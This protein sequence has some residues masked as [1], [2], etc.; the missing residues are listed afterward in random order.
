MKKSKWKRV[1]AFGLAAVMLLGSAGCTKKDKKDQ[2]GDGSNT[3]ADPSLAK[4]YVYHYEDLNLDIGADDYNISAFRK[5]GDKLELLVN[6][7]VY[8][9]SDDNQVFYLITMNADGSNCQ[10]V[11]MESLGGGNNSEE[12]IA[13][14]ED[15]ETE[16]ENDDEVR[17]VDG[18]QTEDY[19]YE[20]SYYQGSCLGD[21]GVY[22][23]RTHQTESYQNGEYNST[24]DVT[25]C[26]WNKDGSFRNGVPFDLTQYQNE[27]TYSYISKMIAIGD[28]SIALLLGGDQS[29]LISIDENGNVKNLQQNKDMQEVFSNDPTFVEGKDGKLLVSY[30]TDD[31]SKMYLTTYDPKNNTKGEVYEVPAEARNKGFY[32]FAAG[33]DK[34]VVF[35]TDMGVFAFNLGDKEIT[36]VMDYVN[37]DLASYGLNNL[38]C[39]DAT[40]FIASYN[41]PVDYRN[42]VAIFSYVKPEDIQD[43]KVMVMAGF[44]ID[45]DV[46]RQVINFNKK[47]NEYRIT[48]RD[49]SDFNTEDDY[50][51]GL[52]KLNNDIIAGDVPDILQ[53]NSNM[54]IDSFAA[55]GVLE[56]IDEWIKND[57]ELS[58]LDFMDNIFEAFRIEGKLYRVIPKYT[59]YTWIG[60]KSMV[61]D[62][63]GWKM[64][65]VKQAA[66]KLNG[67]KSIFGMN[68]TRDY[69][70]DMM[71][72][73]NGNEFVDVKTGKCNF[74][75]QNFI[76]ML[77]YAKTLPTDFESGM[78]DEYW[79][80][81]WE[82]YQSQ[83]RE[84]RTLLM[85]L[86]ISDGNSVRYNVNGMMG[87]D[88]SY[89][90]FPTESGKGSYIEAY[91]S[92]AMSAKSANK[93]GAWKFLR[94][95]LSEDYQK[96][97]DNEY[98][99][100]YGLSVL[101]SEVRK[102]VDQAM[103]RPYW[104]DF[105][106]S[107]Q[108]YDDTIYINEQE[109]VVNPFSQ[110]QA[111]ALFN[112]LCSVNTPSYY[113]EKVMEIVS[114]EVAAFFAG[115][116]SASDVADMIQNRVQLYVNENK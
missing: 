102:T 70:I 80:H 27:E 79:D 103:E 33:Y 69:F 5:N 66:S 1:L 97:E 100:T 9:G 106:G 77:E 74:N 98:G 73:Y 43:K 71:M 24:V 59:V 12:P 67:D 81:Y 115:S 110:A 95:F 104:I 87:E 39:I 20:Y 13:I 61:G 41:D 44:Y 96:N 54:P 19:S 78:D 84:N 76:D 48:I 57:E 88:V 93:E 114:E 50:S 40:H 101:K 83:Y 25:I 107:K 82:T 49:Y 72:K 4:Q 109:I 52:T 113:D 60:K 94:V 47:S 75:T 30:Y 91:T 55:K 10:K 8:D 35:S 3:A 38:V 15:I 65:D 64:S 37:S 116:K 89:I 45:S 31:W 42:C 14:P 68:I 32:N 22:A 58:K 23:L 2:N 111:D 108:Y 16:A 11:K 46:K 92:F 99:Y 17:I 62:R 34:D 86:N 26:C 6:A 56:N 7:Y 85:E 21:D 28:G 53:I 18:E 63:T 90:G 36:R 29:G 112:F 105:D 51:A